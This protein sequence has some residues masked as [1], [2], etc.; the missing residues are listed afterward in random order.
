M[1]FFKFA[2]LLICL[3]FLCVCPVLVYADVSC[4]TGYVKISEPDSIIVTNAS[5]CPSGHTKLSDMSG[6]TSVTNCTTGLSSGFCTYYSE[7]CQSGKYFDGTTHK[8]C[9]AGSYCDGSGT[10]TPGVSGCSKA[11]PENS[12]STSGATKCTCNTGYEMIGGACVLKTCESGYYL[13][14]NECTVCP[15]GSYCANNI[16]TA[17]D[18]GYTTDATGTTDVSQC[19]TTCEQQCTQQQCPDNATCTHGATVTTGKQYVGGTCNAEQTMCEV[20]ITCASGYDL[21][22][23]T[24]V[25]KTC[26]SGYYLNGDDC[27]ICPIGSYCANNIKTACDD[28]YTTDATGAT[29]VSQCYT[30]C[31]QQCTQQACPDNATCT[32][33]TA[34]TTGKQYIGGTCNAEQTMCGIDITCDTGFN[35]VDGGIRLVEKTPVIPVDYREYST[36][37]YGFISADGK[38][39]PNYAA[40][41]LKDKNTWGSVFNYGTVYGRASCQPSMSENSIG[42]MYINENMDAVLDGAMSV[43]DFESGLTAISG[44]DKAEFMAKILNGF[45]QGTKSKQD[46]YDAMFISF[47]TEIET[48]YSATS[49]GQ[50]CYCQ[51]T[52]FISTNGVKQSIVDAPWIFFGDF[53]SN[54]SCGVNCVGNCGPQMRHAGEFYEAFRAALYGVF[55]TQLSSAMCEIDIIDIP[56]GYYLPANTT[57]PV[58]CPENNYCPGLAG[59]MFN[60]TESQGKNQCPDGTTSSVGAVGIEQCT[61]PKS[62]YIGDDIQ[63][64]LT[65]VKPQTARVMVFDVL[66]ELYYGGLSN[67]PKPINNGTD[68]QFRILDGDTPYW[69]HDYTVK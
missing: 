24:C 10:A 40:V 43:E 31:E 3:A 19:Y 41:G 29:D 21:I 30:T 9:I 26:E 33:G 17:C 35:E 55:E 52:S 47:A 27:E 8:T 51:L 49:S 25:L 65:T 62:L 20:N 58:Q 14:G 6:N 18:D 7:P 42:Y 22:G 67:T 57:E 12:T 56:V 54:S 1:R 16:K 13:N 48:D 69:M 63:M 32:H 15:V 37:A 68:K 44:K 46:V 2:K 36:G 28:G 66:G 64:N 5:S 34:I 11:C 4:P 60:S 38:F 61:G 59:A 50:Y 53:D 45:R 23:G 39:A